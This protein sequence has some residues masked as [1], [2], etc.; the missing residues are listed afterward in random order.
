[1]ARTRTLLTLVLAVLACPSLA[2]AQQQRLEI[3]MPSR[4]NVDASQVRFN[5]ASHPGRLMA[6]V[7]LPDGYDP[8]KR[9][10]V[11]YLLHGAG[12]H[13]RTWVDKTGADEVTAG[14]P[15]IVVMPDAATGFYT[16]WFNGGKRGEPGW[17]RYFIDEVIPA[18]ERR[19]PIRPGRRWHAVAGFSMGGFGTAY[20]ASQ[21][22][23][24]FGSIGPMSGFLAPRRAEMPLAFDAATGQSYSAIY[25]PADGAYVAGHDPVA[26]AGN[27]RHTR[28]FVITGDGVTDAAKTPPGSP[29][30]AVTG[31]LGEG[32]LRFHSED[33]AAALR[34]AGA[35][36]TLTVLRGIHDH[37]YWND[38]LRRLLAWDPFKPVQERP[39]QWSYKT[40]ADRGRAWDVTYRFAE[41][42]EVVQTLSRNGAAYSG[43]GEGTVE[44]CGPGGTGVRSSLPFKRRE[45][46]R[47]V[48]LSVVGRRGPTVR[49][50]VRSTEA[51][52]ARLRGRVARRGATRRLRPATVRLGAGG[53]RTVALRAPRRARTLLRGGPARVRVLARHGRC[54]GGRWS[55]ARRTLRP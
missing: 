10:P 24:Y 15:A 28:A 20:L 44:L 43:S 23:D 55:A 22:P 54:A 49:V 29:Q 18:V 47:A 17:E 19:F 9:W 31:A 34:A 52:R 45:L 40:V 8:S 27:L 51:V 16:N 53:T 6:T 14:L 5:G 42:P 46:G 37:P 30:S 13:F 25:G 21:R 7:L 33:F 39:E 41:A 35:D 4:G 50:R 11:L 2:S 3:P 32:E 26:L 36:V 38:H 48:R 12:E 1:M